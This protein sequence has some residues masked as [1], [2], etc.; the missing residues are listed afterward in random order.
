MVFAFAD[1]FLMGPESS[2]VSA[3]GGEAVFVPVVEAG[4]LGGGLLLA[5]SVFAHAASEITIK[6]TNNNARILFIYIL[7]DLI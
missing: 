4:E 5:D 2:G 3:G 1:G 7:L 6:D